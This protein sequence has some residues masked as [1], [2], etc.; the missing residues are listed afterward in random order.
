[1]SRSSVSMQPHPGTLCP[2]PS[3]NPHE[4]S[5][6]DVGR[7]ISDARLSLGC[8]RRLQRNRAI[9]TGD[10]HFLRVWH[11]VPDKPSN[12]AAEVD[13][14][15]CSAWHCNRGVTNMLDNSHLPRR[16]PLY[17]LRNCDF[18]GDNIL[19]ETSCASKVK[20]KLS[21]ISEQSMVLETKA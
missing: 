21:S 17:P 19:L 20:G 12:S 8:P 14:G 2:S 3:T 10:T 15:R 7:L 1:M 16:R 11:N 18:Q 5:A 6:L 9:K 4:V 13:S